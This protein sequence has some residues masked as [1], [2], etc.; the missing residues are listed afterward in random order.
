MT[1][2]NEESFR[3]VNSGPVMSITGSNAHRTTNMIYDTK[4]ILDRRL[5]RE[6][7][8]NKIHFDESNILFD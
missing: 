1:R 2:G 5:A 7:T 6:E 3:L 4:L 8:V